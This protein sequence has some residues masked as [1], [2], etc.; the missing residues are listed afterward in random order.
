MTI[1]KDKIFY[2]KVK[3]GYIPKV[4]FDALATNINQ[5]KYKT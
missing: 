5:Y 1:P 3:K 2:A 4:T